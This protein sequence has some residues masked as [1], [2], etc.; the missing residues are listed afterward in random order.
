MSTPA[1][2]FNRDISAEHSE[3]TWPDV[4]K[5]AKKNYNI[6]FEESV[7]QF[8]NLEMARRRAAFTRWKALENLDKFLIQFEA[9]FIKSGGKVIWAQD[10]NE[11]TDEILKIV[12]RKL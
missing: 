4:I 2:I 1:N 6:A 10:A 12:N 3:S 8:S 9:N 7:K 5:S 11:A